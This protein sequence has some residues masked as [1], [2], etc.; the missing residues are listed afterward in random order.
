MGRPHSNTH[1]CAR[2]KGDNCLILFAFN[3]P[4]A[5]SFALGWLATLTSTHTLATSP[6]VAHNHLCA[7]YK[8]VC[9]G[10]KCLS[11]CFLSCRFHID[12]RCQHRCSWKCLSIALIL[13]TVVLSAMLTY[14]AGEFR[15]TFSHPRRAQ[16]YSSTRTCACVCVWEQLKVMHSMT[17]MKIFANTFAFTNIYSYIREQTVLIKL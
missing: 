4:V 1:D 16:C 6:N 3:L 14:F 8:C 9:I 13:V 11:F 17:N 2:G 12:K 7:L 10:L 15:E 5:L